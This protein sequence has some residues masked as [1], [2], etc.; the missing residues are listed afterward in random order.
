MCVGQS[1]VGI[2]VLSF[3]AAAANHIT[4]EIIILKTW[5]NENLNIFSEIL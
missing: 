2:S 1:Y 3:S 5:C 4:V